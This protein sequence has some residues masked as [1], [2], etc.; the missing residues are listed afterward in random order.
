M[1][2]VRGESGVVLLGLAL[3]VLLLMAE[4]CCSIKMA[5]AQDLI[6]AVTSAIFVLSV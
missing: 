3:L 1:Y 5:E 2:E 4:T 6:G